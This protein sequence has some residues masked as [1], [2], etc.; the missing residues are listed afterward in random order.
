MA[1]QVNNYYAEKI[2]EFI[3][4]KKEWQPQWSGKYF[5]NEKSAVIH[6]LFSIT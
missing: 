2:Q 4:L 5:I 3:C 6:T 1:E